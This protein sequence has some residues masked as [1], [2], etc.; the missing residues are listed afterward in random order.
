M[1]VELPSLEGF[2]SHV[3]VTL[4][5]KEHDA[6]ALKTAA[7]N[8]FRAQFLFTVKALLHTAT[9]KMLETAHLRVLWP[10]V[11]QLQEENG[12]GDSSKKKVE[13]SAPAQSKQVLAAALQ[14]LKRS[15]MNAWVF[16]GN[17]EELLKISD[18][19]CWFRCEQCNRSYTLTEGVDDIQRHCVV[20]AD[21][22]K[23]ARKVFEG[24]NEDRN[25]GTKLDADAA[26]ALVA[27][28]AIEP[29]RGT[30]AHGARNM[31]GKDLHGTKKDKQEGSG[32]QDR[33][34]R[35]SLRQKRERVQ[36]DGEV[37][38]ELINEE[39]T[40]RGRQSR[41]GVR[42]TS[43]GNANDNNAN[44]E[45]N[46]EGAAQSP[47][48]T[49]TGEE[50]SSDLPNDLPEIAGRIEGQP[51]VY[52][53][54]WISK[55][56]RRRKK[57]QESPG[58]MQKMERNVSVADLAEKYHN[59]IVERINAYDAQ[60]DVTFQ[61]E[62]IVDDKCGDNGDVEYWVSW[63][64]YPHP[65]FNTWQSAHDLGLEADTLI[66]MYNSLRSAPHL[67]K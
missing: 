17:K 53:C 40:R 11:K 37:D 59:D 3:C 15:C 58:M 51:V 26:V 61:V 21:M 55:G 31:K 18:D 35:R 27:E 2:L 4:G 12:L 42:T 47:V 48:G 24:R 39:K 57:K 28:A 32:K 16:E 6:E 25:H 43:V 9:E 36:Q 7:M 29:V 20:H 5:Y 66:Q 50:E 30:D 8:F 33:G 65:L 10:F 45:R 41:K 38:V 23:R 1:N 56:S 19:C 34:R 13:G 60:H 67:S 14:A 44:K 49:G 62:C 52:R 54:V 63:K 22:R 64:G 46:S